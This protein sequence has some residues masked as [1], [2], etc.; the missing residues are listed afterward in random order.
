MS[1]A[2]QDEESETVDDDGEVIIVGVCRRYPPVIV[3]AYPSA[4]SIF[5]DVTGNT[6]WCGEYVPR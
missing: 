5:P 4:E 6:D 3:V 2:E 1:D